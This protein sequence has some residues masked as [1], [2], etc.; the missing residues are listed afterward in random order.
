MQCSIRITDMMGL[1]D[2]FGGGAFRLLADGV[3]IPIANNLFAVVDPNKT[4]DIDALF[5]IPAD[6]DRVELIVGRSNDTTAKIPIQISTLV[7][8]VPQVSSGSEVQ[9]GHFTYKLLKT[10][11][12]QYSVGPD[13]KPS[14]WALECSIRITDVMGL[15]DHFGGDAFRLLADGVEIPIANN[16]FAV[17][18]PNRTADIDTLFIIPADVDR[19]ELIVG[20][21]NDATAKIPIPI[22][23]LAKS[24]PQASSGSEVQAGH[25]TYKLLKT[26]L[27]PPQTILRRAGWQAIQVG[28]G[29][30]YSYN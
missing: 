14:K 28:L 5:I 15:S 2:H 1:S 16:L 10:N 20:R 21:S 3:E 23:T 8:S 13:G 19:V 18:D 29:V 4:A 30:F 24:V 17:I 9:A 11:L 22:S 12:K 27:K 7:K 25:F 6:V 26:N